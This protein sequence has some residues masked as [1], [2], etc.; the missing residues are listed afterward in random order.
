MNT[1]ATKVY[2]IKCEKTVTPEQGRCL[3]HETYFTN[4]NTFETE[5]DFCCLD[6]GFAFCPPPEFDM[7]AWLERVWEIEPTD[8]E[9]REIELE[10]V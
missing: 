9:L 1:M 2:C 8:E 7:E 3:G 6:L 5:V 10:A 4:L